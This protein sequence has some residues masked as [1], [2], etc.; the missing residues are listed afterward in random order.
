HGITRVKNGVIALGHFTPLLLAA[1][2]GPTDLVATLLDAGADVNAKDVRG[3]TPLMLASACDHTSPDVIRLLLSKGADV[4]AKSPE[5]ETALDWALKSGPTPVVAPLKAAGALA[6]PARAAAAGAAAPMALRQ[7]VERSLAL[8]EKTS[9]DY[10]AKG[11]CPAC[12]AQQ[13]TDVVA[14]AARAKGLRVDPDEALNR[15]KVTKIRY[16]SLAPMFMQRVDVPG[17]PVVPLYSLLALASAATP[18]DW[19]TDAMAINVATQQFADGRWHLGGIPRPPIM[20][21]DVTLTA[22][23]IRALKTYAPP[24]RAD[25][26]ARVDTAMAWLRSTPTVTADDRNMQLLGLAWGGADRTSL[27]TL[28]DAILATQRTDG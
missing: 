6:S 14:T 19:T 8:L 10:F 1:A 7:A 23:A 22:L 26:G 17:S 5:G 16:T 13:I 28:A 12:H 20:D 11:G 2:G 27:R 25:I 21:G 9:A 3:M 24:A 18:P 4:H 15:Q